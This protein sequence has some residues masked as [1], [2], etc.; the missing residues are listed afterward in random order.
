MDTKE[1][2]KLEGRIK[3]LSQGLKQLSDDD[4]LTELI[5]IIHQ[6]GWT[7]PAELLFVSGLVDA[8]MMKTKTLRNLKHTLISGS[9]LVGKQ[10]A[11]T[12]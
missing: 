12:H 2:T 9:R 4:E 7:T 1:L 8:L 5:K 11:V 3:E 6:P 10:V